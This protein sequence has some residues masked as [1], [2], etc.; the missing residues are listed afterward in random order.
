VTALKDQARYFEETL[1]EIKKR[2]DE[3]QSS[4]EED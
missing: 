4:A 2:I 1:Q 3:I